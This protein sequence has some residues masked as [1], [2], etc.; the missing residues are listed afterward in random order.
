MP[1]AAVMTRGGACRS[2]NQETIS[3]DCG[4]VLGEERKRGHGPPEPQLAMLRAA[5]RNRGGPSQGGPPLLE[6]DDEL[7]TL[8]TRA[9]IQRREEG[10]T[11]GSRSF[12]Q[13]QPFV[14]LPFP[15]PS[16][17][18][19]SLTPTI[20]AAPLLPRPSLPCRST[21][22][23]TILLLLHSLT[24]SLR[25][26]GTRIDNFFLKPAY[27]PA[28]TALSNSATLV[29]RSSIPST[30]RSLSTLRRFLIPLFPKPTGEDAVFQGF[31][32]AIHH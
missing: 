27:R 18:L 12:M 14:N 21:C 19:L 7:A 24:T 1:A 4:S 26:R 11:C 13:R 5:V 29:N 17:S 10:R 23:S 2:L 28:T 32:A 22:P 25:H 3:R 16:S 30:P 9:K 8:T 15:P 6:S 31:P 20:A